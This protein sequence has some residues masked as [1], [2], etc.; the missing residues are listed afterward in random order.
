MLE[1]NK[2]VF[3]ISIKEWSIRKISKIEN[4]YSFDEE[5]EKLL[6]IGENILAG[7]NG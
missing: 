5:K 2:T 7:E 6:L 3:L 4:H 1:N